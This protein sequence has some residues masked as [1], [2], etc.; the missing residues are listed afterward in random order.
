MEAA[1]QTGKSRNTPACPAAAGHRSSAGAAAAQRCAARCRPHAVRHPVAS[2]ARRGGAVRLR[3][4]SAGHPAPLVV[5]VD[6]WVEEADTRGSLVG[7]L[8]EVT[9]TTAPLDLAPGESCLLWT[10]GITEAM[11]G[12]VGEELF[13]EER[14]RPR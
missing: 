14:L 11:G 8:P 9:S 6:G 5:R 12:P 2:V 1:V 13:G 10:D 7:A 3:V 4:T